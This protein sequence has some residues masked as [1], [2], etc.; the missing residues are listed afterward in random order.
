MQLV[1]LPETRR[2]IGTQKEA[3]AL[4]V[5]FEV[6]DIPISKQ[7]LMDELNAIEDRHEQELQALRE[8]SGST[9]AE[10]DEEAAEES[11]EV[12]DD[13]TPVVTPAVDTPSPVA[14]TPAQNGDLSEQIE[15]LSKEKLLPVLSAALARLHEVAGFSGWSAFTKDVYSWTP[16]ALAI[17]R[18]MGMLMMAFFKTVDGPAAKPEARRAITANPTSDPVED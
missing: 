6:R 11:A 4:K 2:Y 9:S 1:W 13:A 18:G 3:K 17:E 7:E 8:Q 12:V 10:I 16:A 15:H 5:P 14:H